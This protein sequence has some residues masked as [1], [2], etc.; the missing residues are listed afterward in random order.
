MA[1]MN[2]TDIKITI[3]YNIVVVYLNVIL[4]K[5]KLFRIKIV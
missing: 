1:N 2:N 4:K 5:S 3:I